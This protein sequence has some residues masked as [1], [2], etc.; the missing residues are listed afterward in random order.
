VIQ[1]NLKDESGVLVRGRNEKGY[2]SSALLHTPISN[3]DY[4]VGRDRVG[5]TTDM[6]LD[7]VK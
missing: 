7:A 6:A 1:L 2:E 3:T 4:V 5:E